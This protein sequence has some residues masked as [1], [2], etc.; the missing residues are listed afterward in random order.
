MKYVIFL[1]SEVDKINFNEV[2][3]TDPES[4]R[5]SLEG[6]SIIKYIGEMPES[7]KNLKWKS[8]EY[9]HE[10]IIH[11]IY[12]EAEWIVP[13]ENITENTPLN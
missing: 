3:N 10:E 7:V 11:I 6:K 9:T 1:F 12:T 4:L 2:L 13:V 5:V 8:A